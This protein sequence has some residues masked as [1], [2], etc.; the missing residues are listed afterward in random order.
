[1]RLNLLPSH[2]SRHTELV[3]AVSWDGNRLATG[4]D[5]QHIQR[6]SSAAQPSSQVRL[7]CSVNQ[8]SIQATM[9]FLA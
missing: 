1:M 8:I 3:S 7:P 4:G 9:Y 5:D 2:G 6:W